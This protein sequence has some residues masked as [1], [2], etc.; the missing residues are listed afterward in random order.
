MRVADVHVRYAL[1]RR[2]ALAGVSF[3]VEPGELVAVTGPHGSGKTTLAYL[4]MGLLPHAFRAEV[5]GVVE[6]A[7]LD[8]VREGPGG[9]AGVVGLTLQ[10]PYNQI[11]GARDTVYDEV[12]FG[13]ENLGLPREEIARRV[14]EALSRFGLARLS[15]RNPFSLSGGEAQRLAIAS[16]W[17]LAP[18]VLVLDEPTSQLDPR[19][20]REVMAAVAE[21]RRNDVAI[22]LVEHRAEWIAASADRVLVLDGGR[23]AAYGPARSVYRDP[24]LADLARPLPAVARI[25]EALTG[26]RA[27]DDEEAL[28][29]LRPF[30]GAGAGAGAARRPGEVPPPA[31]D[32]PP[33]VEF[34]GVTF[35]YVPGTAVFESFSLAL[36]GPGVTALVGENGGGKSTLLRL[37]LGLLRPQSGRVL[38]C[39]E[40]AARRSP[41]ELARQVAVAFQNP[42]DQLFLPKALA[43]AAYG[44][45]NLGRAKGE[46]EAEALSAMEA[47][48]IA[49]HRDRHPYD[50]GFGERKLLTVA[51]AVAMRTPVVVLDEPTMA[52]DGPSLARLRALCRRLAEEGRL[53]V[54]TSHDVEFVADVADRVVVLAAGEV[55]CDGTPDEVFGSDEALAR[56]GL[57]PTAAS[58]L[59]RALGWRERPAK[60]ACFVERAR[61]WHDRSVGGGTA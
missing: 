21:A 6:V 53:V 26:T 61:A 57:A 1:A 39:G 31:A 51:A 38:V 45:R 17:A 2:E 12:A 55:V 5:R 37:L 32:R 36:G 15:E 59:A 22:V 23:P 24:G 30:A 13:L 52:Q 49:A 28:A 48:G 25:A 10:N 60:A 8:P 54:L 29:L 9:L 3:A 42:D 47:L 27:L 40:D 41:A 58:R 4:L 18:R 34:E 19:G 7:G 16:V 44:A 50:L 35:G 56:A 20:A 14:E 33:R 43:E 11:T 46:A